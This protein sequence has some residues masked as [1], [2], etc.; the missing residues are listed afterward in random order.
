M[1]ATR[2][3]VS[4]LSRSMLQYD[5]EKRIPLR[6]LSM[7]AYT[8]WNKQRRTRITNRRG[9]IAPASVNSFT[10]NTDCVHAPGFSTRTHAM[11]MRTKVVQV[12]TEFRLNKTKPSSKDFEVS[13]DWVGLGRCIT[14]SGVIVRD[15]WCWAFAVE[16]YHSRMDKQVLNKWERRK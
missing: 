2:V 11:K 8:F 15:S 6:A 5:A 9:E 10:G 12:T 13:R 14:W 7:D 16:S 3:S 1:T 4:K